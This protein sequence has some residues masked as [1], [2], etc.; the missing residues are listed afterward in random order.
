MGVFKHQPLYGGLSGLWHGA[1]FAASVDASC[2]LDTQGQ[3]RQHKRLIAWMIPPS[4]RPV[5]SALRLYFKRE[6]W[7]WGRGLVCAWLGALPNQ[8]GTVGSGTSICACLTGTPMSAFGQKWLSTNPRLNQTLESKPLY[9]HP[10]VQMY[11]CM[12]LFVLRV[13]R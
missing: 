9:E 13:I 3:G 8:P 4:S 2:V 10:I 1:W 12:F 7:I 5:S 11:Y 6:I